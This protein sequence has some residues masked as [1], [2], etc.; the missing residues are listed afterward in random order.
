MTMLKLKITTKI[1][2]LLIGC[3]V[4]IILAVTIMRVWRQISFLQSRMVQQKMSVVCIWN[5]V[6]S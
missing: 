1:Q 5:P 3:T 4:H 2:L 6:V